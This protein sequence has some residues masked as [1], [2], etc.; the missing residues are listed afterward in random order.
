MGPRVTPYLDRVTV[1]EQE[2]T[3]SGIEYCDRHVYA[4]TQVGQDAA[5]RIVFVR[6]ERNSSIHQYEIA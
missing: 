3:D 5:N 6:G 4:F 2:F 1:G